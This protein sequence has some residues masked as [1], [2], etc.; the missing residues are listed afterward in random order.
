VLRLITEGKRTKELAALL[1]VSVK[2][3]ESH[4][5]RLMDK[6][7]IHETAGLVRYALQR[8]LIQP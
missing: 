5:T 1:G 3:A 7:N 6:L 4:R 2:T 8:G